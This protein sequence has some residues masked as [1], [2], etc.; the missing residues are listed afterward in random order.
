MQH[1][2]ERQTNRHTDIHIDIPIDKKE[3]HRSSVVVD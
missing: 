1:R 2:M 3:R